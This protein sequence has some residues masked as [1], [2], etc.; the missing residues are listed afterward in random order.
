MAPHNE[1]ERR[2]LAQGTWQ[3]EAFWGQLA[4]RLPKTV[5]T[6]NNRNRS[7]YESK[8]Q[9]NYAPAEILERSI[10]TLGGAYFLHISLETYLD[11][12]LLQQT[13]TKTASSASSNP[14]SSVKAHALTS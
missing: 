14:K 4:T 3:I 7:F 11:L 13:S 9:S 1:S 2:S 8:M 5:K 12:V 10:P 6:S